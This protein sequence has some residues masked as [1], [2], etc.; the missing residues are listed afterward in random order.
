MYKRG[1]LQNHCHHGSQTINLCMNQQNL[2]TYRPPV[3]DA[4]VLQAES[5][6]VI[7]PDCDKAPEPQ[8]TLY[9]CIN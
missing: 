3:C 6:T 1:A 2:S 8:N 4:G 7:V 9:N 5:S